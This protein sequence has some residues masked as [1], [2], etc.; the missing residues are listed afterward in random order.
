MDCESTFR[1]L[2]GFIIYTGAS[3]DYGTGNTL[4]LPKDFDSYKSPSKVVLHLLEKYIRYSYIV[5]LN[6]YYNSPKLTET[7]LQLQTD[8]Y[9]TLRKKKGLPRDFWN[10]KHLKGDPPQKQFQGNI[11]ALRWNDITKTKSIKYVSMLS[12]VHTGMLI[13]SGKKKPE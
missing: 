12:T 6:N 2:L 11:M 9:G 8:C 1:Y 13:N 5:T 7:L 4:N 3:T 10:W